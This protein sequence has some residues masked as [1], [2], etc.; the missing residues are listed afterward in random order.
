MRT[1][2]RKGLVALAIWVPVGM[3]YGASGS[4]L[5]EGKDIYLPHAERATLEELDNATG[6]EGV[7]ITTLNRMNVRAFLADN[8]ATNNVSGF[9]SI[10]NGSFVGASGMFS[11]QCSHTGLD[12]SQCDHITLSLVSVFWME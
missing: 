4:E 9:N 5:L 12:N 7:D 1:S 10:D 2:I 6:R 11:V 3:S 8:S